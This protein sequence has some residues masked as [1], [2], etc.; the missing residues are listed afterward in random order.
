MAKPA[1]EPPNIRTRL[2]ILC[3]SG[4]FNKNE[5]VSEQ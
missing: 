3:R 2:V 5:D 4:R 1:I